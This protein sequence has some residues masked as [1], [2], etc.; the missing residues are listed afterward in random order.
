MFLKPPKTKEGEQ[1][2]P[3]GGKF[4]AGYRGLLS[5]CIR[6]RWLTL[7]VVV[8]IFVS[9]LRGFGYVEQS[10]FPPSTRPQFMVDLWLPQGRTIPCHHQ[11]KRKDYPT[12]WLNT[13]RPT[14]GP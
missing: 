4:Y 3:Y 10:F 7:G 11:S 13:S 6:Q 8:V 9:A 12:E 14:R 5:T 2:D 1:Q